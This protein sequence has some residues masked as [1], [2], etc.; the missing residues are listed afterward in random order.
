MEVALSS[1][2]GLITS[3]YLM[4]LMLIAIPIGTF[5][6]ALP[7]LG[8]KIGI[9]LLIPFVFGMDPVAGA[10]FLLAMHS[11]VH[12][13]GA[14]PSILFGVPGDGPTAA[15]VLD[16]YAMAKNGEAGRAL[17]ASFGASGI[18]GLIGAIFLGVML[19]LIQPIILSFSPAEFFFVAIL[20]ITFIAVLSGNNLVKGLVVGLFGLLVATIG[21]DPVTGGPRYT[22]G[23][24]FLWDGL[25]VIT[26]VLA[27]F[28]IPEMIAL[29]L[30]KEDLDAPVARG[31]TL[32]VNTRDVWNG[33]WDCFRHWSLTLRT[34][35]IGAFIG[36]IPGLGG[37]AAS[38]ICYGHAVQ[39]SKT[40]EKFG[41]GM[42]EGVIAPE[43]AN[44]SKEGGALLP[45]LFFAVP[46][47]SGMALMLGAFLMLGIQPGPTM[48]T[49]D[50]PLVWSLIWALAVANVLC[51]IVLIF[52]SPWLS[53]LAHMKTSVMVP[54]VL[55]FALLGCYLGASAWENL[56]LLVVFGII[57]YMFKRHSWPR[58]P[59]VIGLVLGPIAEDSL[60][61]A[62]AL[63]G[64]SF[65]LRPISLVLITMIIATIVYYFWKMRKPGAVILSDV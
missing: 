57:G 58:P 15:T 1:L 5:F 55:M 45:T 26:G 13:G 9:V 49:E 8:G 29:A 28:A 2:I 63:D 34:S 25:D 64:M 10:V 38:W 48:L 43:T 21:L 60:L 39:S 56:L 17:G 30:K 3:P 6:G 59:F 14:V 22:F 35:M 20:G 32:K 62:F 11:V 16:G 47:S 65:V 24:L 50:L 37:D 61:K 52:C 33:V 7:G 53:A 23:Q 31:E 41:H 42:V 18:G 12:T 44:N 54:F 36:M 46:G 4:M 27:M 40:P 51:A 19:P